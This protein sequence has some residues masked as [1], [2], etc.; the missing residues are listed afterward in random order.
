M[1]YKKYLVNGFIKAWDFYS[2]D[3]H[4]ILLLFSLSAIYAYLIYSAM[5]YEFNQVY[6]IYFAGIGFSLS[7]SGVTFTY[8]QVETKKKR[9]E[10]LIKISKMFLYSAIASFYALILSFFIIN[11]IELVVNENIRSVVNVLL[12][13]PVSAFI[14]DS[15]ISFYMALKDIEYILYTELKKD[16]K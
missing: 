12:W 14:F 10:K 16:L 8:C 7:L 13:I 3:L 6:N 11:I 1:N 15:L 2:F 4:K 5:T 9:V